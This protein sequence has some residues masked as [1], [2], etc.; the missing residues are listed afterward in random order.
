MSETRKET[1]TYL[2]KDKDKYL[3]VTNKPTSKFSTI[4]YSTSKG[5]AREFTGL[6]DLS[7]DLTNHSVIKRIHIEM[8]IEEEIEIE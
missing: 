5:D 4:K 8:N 1:I 6:E 2:I 3:W 7:I